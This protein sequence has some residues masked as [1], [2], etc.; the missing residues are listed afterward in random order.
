MITSCL[1]LPSSPT[2]PLSFLLIS[3]SHS[4]Q[5]RRVTNRISKMNPRPPVPSAFKKDFPNCTSRP[6]AEPDKE[7]GWLNK[8]K[9]LVWVFK[10]IKPTSCQNNISCSQR[11]NH[12]KIA[13][14]REI[15][16]PAPHWILRKTTNRTDLAR[17]PCDVSSCDW[18]IS[19][20]CTIALLTKS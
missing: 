6:S 8:C 13:A 9:N 12:N 17:I 20:K 15:P 10:M 19:S 16:Y 18:P 2:Y 11:N 5:K 1:S 3:F 7:A 14:P 4:P